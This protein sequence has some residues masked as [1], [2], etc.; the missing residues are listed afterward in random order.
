MVN[1]PTA[2][3]HGQVTNIL[4]AN[5]TDAQVASGVFMCGSSVNPNDLLDKMLKGTPK[6][7]EDISHAL[8]MP[9]IGRDRILYLSQ[10]VERLES[11]LKR[12]TVEAPEPALIDDIT[13]ELL[14]PGTVPSIEPELMKRA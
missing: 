14:R 9:Q 13:A 1:K 7:K 11:L 12:I 3:I 5:L 8:A 10:K 2:V 6:D 4:A